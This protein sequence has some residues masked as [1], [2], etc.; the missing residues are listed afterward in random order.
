MAPEAEAEAEGSNIA[1]ADAIRVLIVDD[2]GFMRSLI[3]GMLRSLGVR[4]I[5]HGEDGAHALGLLAGEAQGVDLVI[6]D[7][8]MPHMDGMEFM[9][10]L[11]ERADGVAVLVLSGKGS[12]LLSSV[13]LM[14]SAFG[15][16]VLG[17]LPK[18]PTV[19]LLREALTR[20]RE[21]SADRPSRPIVIPAAEVFAALKTG[22]FEPYFQPKVELKT[23]KVHGA[24]ALARW[25]SPQRGVLSPAAFIAT[26]E[27][28]GWID[29]LTCLM[30]DKAVRWRR[31]WQQ[32][33]LA[34]PVNVNLS[35]R[36]LND[37]RFS[38]RLL[39]IVAAARGVPRDVI[40]EVTETTAM[41]DVGRCLESLIRLRLRGFGLSIDDFGTGH[42]SL[43]QL[44]RVPYTELKID[45]SFVNGA[46]Q[47][48]RL[49]AVLEASLE[50]ARKL[51][52]TTVAEGVEAKEDWEYLLS[53]G[54]QLGQG[55]FI[56]TPMRGED[57]P[58]WVRAWR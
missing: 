22:E 39:S 52:L 30:I 13:E 57:F 6:C 35:M 50:I 5:Y 47:S 41:T 43:Q 16:R 34:I 24:E 10:L 42:S 18:P 55:Y 36:S 32:D 40:L 58:R 49:Q 20:C 1:Q 25:V 7:L 29:E 33:G 4:E 28:N 53:A 9:R 44:G 56:A 38:G 2:D 31:R 26:V 3:D 23:R 11:A 21:R 54:C 14:A 48:P 15:L 17:A 37:T 19:A 45:R 27:D 12:A 8:D 51:N 46:W